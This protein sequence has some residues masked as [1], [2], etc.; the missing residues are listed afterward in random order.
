V[1]AYHQSRAVFEPNLANPVTARW[2]A[3]APP[4]VAAGAL[5]VFGFPL[6]LG[7]VRLG[8]L[9]L[10]RDRPGSLTDDQHADA[11]VL[12]GVAARA[13]LAMQAHAP[14]GELAAELETGADLRLIV[15]QAAG[16]VAAQLGASVGEALV[17]LRAF[18]FTNGRPISE[19]AESVV[20]RRLRFE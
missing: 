1:D 10:Y 17:R 4:A 19:V 6:Q 16:M 18:A 9:N 12:A 3:F 2:L 5:A 8:A 15:H 20:S 7:S 14:P 13:V 11:L